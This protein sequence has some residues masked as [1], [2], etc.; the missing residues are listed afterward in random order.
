MTHR[1]DTIVKEIYV[2][3]DRN[4][5]TGMYTKRYTKRNLYTKKKPPQWF[6]EAF[7]GPDGTRTRDPM[8]DRHVF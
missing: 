7:C 1:K 4:M 2:Y 3:P 6:V 8:R 5:Y